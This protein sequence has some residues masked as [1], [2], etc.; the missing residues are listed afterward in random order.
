[1]TDAKKILLIDNDAE[2]LAQMLVVYGYNVETQDNC[3]EVLGLLEDGNIYNL[4]LLNMD[5]PKL[6][7]WYLLKMIREAGLYNSIPIICLSE[8]SDSRRIVFALNSGV[9]DFIVR[10]CEIEIILARIAAVLRRFNQ[11][12]NKL[13]VFNVT[14][15]QN[16]VV[17][18]LTEREKDV[19]LLVTQ[20]LDNKSIAEELYVSTITVKAHLQSIFKKLNV[21]NR[22]QAVLAFIENSS[23]S[24]E[25]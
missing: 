12:F 3:N 18:S 17:N 25:K 21:K 20:G 24:K 19:L 8:D 14:N 5:F 4:I 15:K 9:D 11:P 1:M 22:T 10:P 13:S 16:S 2:H 6:E 7:A 23:I